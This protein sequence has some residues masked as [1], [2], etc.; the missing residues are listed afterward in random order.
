MGTRYL[1]PWQ[2][3]EESCVWQEQGKESSAE[4][5]ARSVEDCE[6]A[7]PEQH[8]VKLATEEGECHGDKPEG[9]EGCAEEEVEF[10]VLK[11]P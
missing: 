1:R 9:G 11:G 8:C 5:K 10:V 7:E 4:P 3:I 6:E 2:T